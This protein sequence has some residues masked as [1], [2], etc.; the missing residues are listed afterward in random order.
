[1]N[2]K[3]KREDNHK[4]ENG[5]SPKKITKHQQQ[6]FFKTMDFIGIFKVIFSIVDPQNLF[7]FRN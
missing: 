3:K 4:L 6:K 1:M 7:R 5:N 2:A